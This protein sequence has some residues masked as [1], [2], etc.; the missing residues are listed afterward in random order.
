MGYS[1]NMRAMRQKLRE[2]CQELKVTS[3]LADAPTD[4]EKRYG[5]RLLGL[6][7]WGNSSL[8]ERGPGKGTEKRAALRNKVARFFT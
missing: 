8:R 4:E 2:A 7:E 5:E 6:L 1:H 3:D